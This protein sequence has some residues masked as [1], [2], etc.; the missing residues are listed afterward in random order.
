MKPIDGTFRDLL[1]HSP[2]TVIKGPAVVAIQ[3][4]LVLGEEVT[5]DGVKLSG[6]Q[7]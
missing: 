1:G 7:A 6:K 4:A 3:I 2:D 5:N